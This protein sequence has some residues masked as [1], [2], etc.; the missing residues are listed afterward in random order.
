MHWAT[1]ECK[2]ARVKR[3]FL[4]LFVSVDTDDNGQ[5]ALIT[6]F[7]V[8]G[9]GQRPSQLTK[10]PDYLRSQLAPIGQVLTN[11]TKKS[12]A[13]DVWNMIC[14]NNEL[15]SNETY[16][17]II[18]YNLNNELVLGNMPFT[19]KGMLAYNLKNELLENMPFTVHE[20]ETSSAGNRT[21]PKA[22]RDS[23]FCLH[24]SVRVWKS[25]I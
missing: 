1:A 8:W 11:C 20:D 14:W 4:S 25:D 19:G 6:T 18:A 15:C 16:I 24:G 2:F 17:K 13:F 9:V 5:S 23:F 21:R 10:G 22:H 3:K 12:L 7:P